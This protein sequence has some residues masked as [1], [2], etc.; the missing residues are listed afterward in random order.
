MLDNG[1][2]YDPSIDYAQIGMLDAGEC[3]V[4]N[5]QVIYNGSNYVSNGTFEGGLG[6]TDWS[7][8]G[9]MVRSSLE[10]PGYQSSYCL[11]IRSSDK[12]WT[13]DNSCE[14]ALLPNTLAAGQ[15]V[16]LSYEARWLHGMAGTGFASE[17][18]L[19][20][21][22]RRPAGAQQP[23]QPGPAQQH[24]YYQCRSGDL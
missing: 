11:H 14:V 21:G 13:G 22:H 16:T 15:T 5:L 23:G 17:R 4:D 2:N 6:L 7:L 8:Q 3:L 12:F 18:Q 1:A 20:G 24:L 19:A 10:S 9:C